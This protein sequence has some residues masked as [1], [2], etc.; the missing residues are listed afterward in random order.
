MEEAEYH[1]KML[2]LC[3][4]IYENRKLPSQAPKKPTFIA[5]RLLQRMVGDELPA[6]EVLQAHRLLYC[7]LDKNIEKK[8]NIQ[9]EEEDTVSEV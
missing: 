2:H 1:E 8:F 5:N 6:N 3:K 4:A 7:T 9:R